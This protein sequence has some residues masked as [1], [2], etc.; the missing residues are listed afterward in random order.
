MDLAKKNYENT[1]LHQRWQQLLI[2]KRPGYRGSPAMGPIWQFSSNK[3]LLYEN[4]IGKQTDRPDQTRQ[5]E[6]PVYPQG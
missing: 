2:P 5:T 4:N 3:N 1:R 6:S